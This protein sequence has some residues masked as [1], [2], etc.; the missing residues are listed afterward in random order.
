[1]SSALNAGPDAVRS[2]VHLSSGIV[3]SARD[4]YLIKPNRPFQLSY[5]AVIIKYHST[6]NAIVP[7]L[8][9]CVAL[10]D[11]LE[12]V[13]AWIRDGVA[14]HLEGPLTSRTGLPAGS[15]PKTTASSYSHANEEGEELIEIGE[16]EI[17]CT[18]E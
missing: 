10:S 16:V 3:S 15:E 8:P 12:E 4:D 13:R 9:G 2:Q 6:Y 14:L 7:D 11:N 5:L 1:M 17:Q 18:T